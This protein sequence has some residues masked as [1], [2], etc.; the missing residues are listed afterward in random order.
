MKLDPHD[1]CAIEKETR[2]M[3]KI[4]KMFQDDSF[5]INYIY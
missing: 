4:F 3:I 5:K 1:F 2:K